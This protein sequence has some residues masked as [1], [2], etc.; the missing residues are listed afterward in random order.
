MHSWSKPFN[1]WISAYLYATDILILALFFLWL[2]DKYQDLKTKRFYI[3]LREPGF[4]LSLFLVGS[5]FSL[6]MAQ[7]RAL[8]F[9]GFFKLLEFSFFFFYLKNNFQKFSLIRF[10]QIFILSAGAQVLFELLQFFRQK[11]LGIK[12]LFESPLGKDISGVAKILLGDEKIIRGYGLLPHPNILAVFLVLALF[13]VIYL[14]LKKYKKTGLEKWGLGFF[15][16]LILSG[17]FLTFSRSVPLAGYLAIFSWVLWSYFR[18]KQERKNILRAGALLLAGLIIFFAIFWPYLKS[19]L[20][21]KKVLDSQSW[22][23]RATYT[24]TAVEMIKTSA[25][26][27]IGQSNFVSFFAHE[28]PLIEAWAFQP[29]HNIYLEIGAENG[30]IALAIFFVFLFL[31]WA[32][33][34]KRIDFPENCLL[35]IFYFILITGLVDHFWWD[36]QQGQI[37][38]WMF[39]GILASYSKNDKKV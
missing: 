19:N 17:L 23:L 30:L 3:R 1:E 26:L 18:E 8:G 13:G 15:G 37:L 36:L 16:I 5:F 22:T 12:Y 32:Q 20:D 2:L 4:F 33:A 34:K 9:Y 25:V 11:S 24:Q 7:N 14:F 21:A 35:F 10:W 39:L 38:F 28:Y 6:A 27:G 31:L 29:V